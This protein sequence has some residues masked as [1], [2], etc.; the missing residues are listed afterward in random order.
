MTVKVPVS[1]TSV[2]VSGSV[3]VPSEARTASFE[4]FQV[5]VEALIP[6]EGS[7]KFMKVPSGMDKLAA[8]FSASSVPSPTYLYPHTLISSSPRTVKVHVVSVDSSICCFTKTPL[9]V[10]FPIFNVT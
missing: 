9:Y 3:T 7:V 4:D 10:V 8:A 1:V 2:S 5:I 6:F